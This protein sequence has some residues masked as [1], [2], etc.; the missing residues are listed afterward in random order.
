MRLAALGLLLVLGLAACAETQGARSAFRS[1]DQVVVPAGETI[2]GDLY[3]SGGSIT[4]NENVRGDVYTGAGT[5]VLN[6]S[7]GGDLVAGAGQAI[8]TVQARRRV[9]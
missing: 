8:E 9:A 7:I 3:A 4:V 5:V 2:E 6:G 1:G